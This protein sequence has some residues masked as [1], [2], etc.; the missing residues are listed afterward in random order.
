LPERVRLA[1]AP[2]DL[3]D[4]EVAV[5]GWRTEAG[6]TTLVCRLL[7]GSAGTIPARWTDL[8]LRVIPERPLGVLASPPAWR[9]LL[10]RVAAVSERCPRPGRACAETGGDMSGQL[11]LALR[12]ETV[13]PAAVWETLP[14]DAQQQVT[15]KLARLVARLLEAERDE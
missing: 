15:L 10:V 5:L 9:L 12:E 14:P 8:P 1:H 4:V 13:V 2:G 11:A 3:R 7:D 6:E